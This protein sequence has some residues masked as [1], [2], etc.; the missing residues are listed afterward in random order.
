MEATVQKDQPPGRL[1]SI[2]KVGSPFAV[3]CGSGMIAT[4]CIQPM[5][6]V[7][8]RM[9]LIDRSSNKISPWSVARSFLAQGGIPTLYAG[10]SAALLKQLIYGTSRLGLFATFEQKLER[11]AHERCQTLGFGGRA[12][13]SLGAGS[14]AAFVGNP[15]EVSLVRMQ[16]DGMRPAEQRKHYSSVF[17]A[18]RRITRQEGILALWKG[19]GPNIIRAMSTNFGQLAFFSESKHRINEYTDLSPGTRTALAA[20]IAGLA[21]TVVSLPFD[22]VKTRLQNQS[23]AATNAGGIPIYSGSIDCFIKT[24]RREGLL[25]FYR[26]FWPYLMRIAPHS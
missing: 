21:G 26:D 3:G 2:I 25:R 7:K 22:F 16:A 18:L 23:L 12:I 13:A 6:T 9:Q 5:D 4:M 20:S 15:T 8:V 24:T 10:L 1:R 17:D 11:R 14:I 19:A